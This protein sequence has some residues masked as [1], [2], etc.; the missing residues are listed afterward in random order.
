MRTKSYLEAMDLWEVV[1][2]DY[3]VSPLLDN[4]TMTQIKNHKERKSKKEK[5]KSCLFA[6]IQNIN[7]ILGKHKGFVQDHLG[8]RVIY[9]L[10]A[11]KQRTLM[12][13]DHM[14]YQLRAKKLIQANGK[15][16][17]RLSQQ[18]VKT[19]LDVEKDNITCESWLIDNGCT[20]HMSYDK[21]LFK[22]LASTKV[23][24][25]LEKGFKVIFKDN[26]HIVKDLT[27]QEMFKLSC[28]RNSKPLLKI[29]TNPEFKF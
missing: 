14:I 20:N 21:E 5:A 7:N 24:W 15:A 2:E 28:S 8:K 13:Q 1:E 11:Q 16:I 19:H 22:Q 18:I 17:R 12:R 4:P 6:I 27:G 29:K 23:K 3:E 25:I 9:A 26:R 10:H